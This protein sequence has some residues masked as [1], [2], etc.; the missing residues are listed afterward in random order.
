[1]GSGLSRD[2]KKVA[3]N[4]VSQALNCLKKAKVAWIPWC[5]HDWMVLLA[6]PYNS[7]F[8]NQ[9]HILSWAMFK[10]KVV[11]V[12]LTVSS[13]SLTHLWFLFPMSFIKNHI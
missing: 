3:Q 9:K 13:T 4:L 1:M 2:T 8:L 12:A 6:L 10:R 5:G 11:V 7:D